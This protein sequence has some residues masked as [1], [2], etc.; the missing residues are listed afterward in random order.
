MIAIK[1]GSSGKIFVQSL[2]TKHK[3]TSVKFAQSQQ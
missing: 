2:Q 1:R 3:T